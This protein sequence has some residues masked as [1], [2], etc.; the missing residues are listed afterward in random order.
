MKKILLFLFL[1]PSAFLF[2]QGRFPLP[3]TVQTEHLVAYYSDSQVDTWSAMDVGDGTIQRGET[4]KSDGSLITSC[5]FILKSHGTPSDY[6][7]AHLYAHT[8]TFHS[9]SGKPTGD[10]LTVSDSL[11]ESGIPTDSTKVGFTFHNPY[12]SVNGT[13]YCLTMKIWDANTTNCI[14][15]GRDNSSPTAAGNM[16]TANVALTWT[17]STS[18]AIIFYV[19][20]RW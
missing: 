6:I 16:L 5:K 12:Q 2:T 1:I 13:A 18:Y 15:A 14:Y 20:G 4:F 3:R 10:T 7:K 9:S 17:A 11:L 19:Y 8:G